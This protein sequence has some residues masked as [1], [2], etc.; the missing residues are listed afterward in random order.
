MANVVQ[1]L[2]ERLGINIGSGT[3]LPTGIY[4]MYN[5]VPGDIT[6]DAV[7]ANPEAFAD[8]DFSRV[9]PEQLNV[10]AV[11]GTSSK[12][13]AYGLAAAQGIMTGIQNERNYKLAKKSIN[14]QLATSKMNRGLAA[15]NYITQQGVRDSVSGAFGG[16]T[17][18]AQEAEDRFG[19]YRLS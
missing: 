2:L 9:N 10:S 4:G 16:S 11:D 7:L 6:A 19:Q 8:Y 5:G 14:D 13:P 17:G 12:A 1:G 18:R 15:E 3:E